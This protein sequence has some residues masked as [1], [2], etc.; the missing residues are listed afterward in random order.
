M[1]GNPIFFFLRTALR[2]QIGSLLRFGYMDTP[3]TVLLGVF[4][5]HD[6]FFPYQDELTATA[7][8]SNF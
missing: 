4:W 8:A 1:I 7:P 2:L 3:P 5:Y 6:V